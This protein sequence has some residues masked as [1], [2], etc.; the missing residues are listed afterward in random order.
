M[1]SLT[2]QMVI[3]LTNRRITTVSGVQR[4]KINVTSSGEKSTSHGS[5]VSHIDSRGMKVYLEYDIY[6]AINRF[7]V[8]NIL[9][10]CG[11]VYRK[12]ITYF[13][14]TTPI[15]LQRILVVITGITREPEPL[16]CFNLCRFCFYTSYSKNKMQS[17]DT[18]QKLQTKIK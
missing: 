9:P 12:A 17:R 11:G 5:Y 13:L 6:F 14:S 2:T 18:G 8:Q 4:S 1:N 10:N 15:I 3:T 7:K 16:T